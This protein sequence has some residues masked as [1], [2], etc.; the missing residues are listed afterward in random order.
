MESDRRLIVLDT[1][2][3]LDDPNVI[4]KIKSSIIVIPMT[5]VEELDEARSRKDDVGASSRAAINNIERLC[6]T[7]DIEKGVKTENG[8]LV[9]IDIHGYIPSDINDNSIIKNAK[10][11]KKRNQYSYSNF[12]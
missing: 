8:S 5:V 12:E 11:I 4:D 1:S 3:F 7:G 6:Q 2:V 10:H 9:F